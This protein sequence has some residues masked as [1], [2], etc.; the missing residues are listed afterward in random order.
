MKRGALIVFEGCDRCGKTTQC[1]LLAATMPDSKVIAFPDRTLPSGQ[2][3]NRYLNDAN[4]D[5][6]DE[7]IHL[8]FAMNRWERQAEM[9]K[10]LNSG[11][12]LIVDRYSYSGIAY[13]VAKG[14]DYEWCR[15]PERGLLQPD[16]VFYLAT[17]EVSTLAGR[18]RYGEERY[19]TSH[20]QKKVSDAFDQM[21]AAAK[22]DDWVKIDA[23]QNITTIS[24]IIKNILQK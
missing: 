2:L 9:E 1:A 22:T 21:Y 14:L 23:N 3:I 4:Q 18:E 20:F 6:S 16:K 10:L 17:N 5:M 15:A 24:K 11:T 19:E 12:T 8:L 13:S 7:A